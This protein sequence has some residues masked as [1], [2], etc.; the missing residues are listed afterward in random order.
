MSNPITDREFHLEQYKMLREEVMELI[1]QTRQLEFYAFGAFG[2]FYAWLYTEN[3]GERA[4]WF[5]APFLALLGSVRSLALLKRIN[6]I[7]RYL[8]GL[9]HHLVPMH[10]DDPIPHRDDEPPRPIGW[11]RHRET[12]GGKWFL[13]TSALLWALLLV[14]TVWL[15]YCHRNPVPPQELPLAVKVEGAIQVKPASP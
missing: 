15:A 7:G 14:A 9:E 10:P 6:E 12:I 5:L 2:A 11:E 3:P 8:R 13:T 1:A 4:A